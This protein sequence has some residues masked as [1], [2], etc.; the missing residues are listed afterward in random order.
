MTRPHADEAMHSAAG[1]RVRQVGPKAS[2]THSRW[3]LWLCSLIVAA[4]A[5]LLVTVAGTGGTAALVPSAIQVG[6]QART[7]T[8][9]VSK[10]K[11]PTPT[12]STPSTQPVA[13]PTTPTTIAGTH[14]TTVIEP[15]STVTD[16][17]DS[18]GGDN[19]GDSNTRTTPSTTTTT[20]TA[21]ATVTSTTFDN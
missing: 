15:V 14:R 18:G 7:V 1:P 5:S 8:S 9:I 17:K 10:P 6:G 19:S 20:S 4:G 16:Q 3:G 11:V 2:L 13:A 21:T 12:V